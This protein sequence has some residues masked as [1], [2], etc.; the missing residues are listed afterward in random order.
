MAGLSDDEL[1]SLI[2]SEMRQSIGYGV[3]KL[4]AARQKA[5]Y[6]YEGLAKGDLS[7]PEIEGRSTVVSTEVRN[8]VESM[9][10]ELM[11]KFA[12]S[13]KVVEAQ[14]T[15]PGDEKNSENV[16]DYLNYLF[17]RQNNGHKITETWFKDALISKAGIIKVWWDTRVEETKEDYK[18]LD[19]VELAQILDDDE[20]E[21]ISHEAYPDEEDVEQRQQAIA[22]LSQALQANPQA[23][24]QIQAQIQDIQAAP[25]KVLHDVTVKRSKKGGKICIEN[26]PPEEFLI[27]RKAKDIANAPFVGH[28]IRRTQSELKSMGYKNVDEITS[29]P[30]GLTWSGETVERISFDDERPF[31]ADDETAL[32]PAMRGIWITECY[33]RADRDGDGIT[34][35]LKVVKAGSTLLEVEE[36]DVAPFVHIVPIVMP[37]RFFGLCPADLAMEPQRIKTNVLRAILDNLYLQVNGRYFAVENQVNLD[38]LLTSRPGGVVR[39]S[40]P[41]AVGRLDQASADIGDA[42]GMLQYLHDFTEE[43]T[44]WSRA[45]N[46]VTDPNSLNQTATAASMQQTRAQIRVDLIARNFA[47]GFTDLFK[48]MLKLVCQHQEEA[49]EYWGGDGNW[50]KIDPREWRNQYTFSINVGIGT[51][52]KEIQVQHLMLLQKSQAE[53]LMGGLPTVT[54]DNIYASSK[55]LAESLGFKNATQFFTDPKTAQPQQP[56]P[57]PETAKVQ[58]QSQLEQQKMQLEMQKHQAQMQQDMELEKFKQQMQA[59]QVEQQNQVQAQREALQMKMQQELE[60]MKAQQQAQVEAARIELEKWKAQLQAETQLIVAQLSAKSALDQAQV[61]A[62]RDAEQSV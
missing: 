38:D 36:V 43:A 21:P 48:M 11:A 20:V 39:V 4:A 58:A 34:E 2:D 56:K 46:G 7:P 30:N 26:V 52:S 6:Y 31:L 27:S 57:D 55:K 37:H 15:K 54:P 47:E 18:G 28:R 13:E 17:W 32:D 59:A 9:L 42:M 14:P 5:L 40:N 45:A 25:P 22:Q 16:T 35:L 41:T 61:S 53:Q 12:S 19:P 1:K 8:V 44:G 49:A 51:G 29:D 60:A 10:P 50:L 23:V 24:Q 33:V 62:A 3:G